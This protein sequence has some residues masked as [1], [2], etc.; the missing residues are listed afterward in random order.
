MG[1]EVHVCLEKVAAASQIRGPPQ[2]Q[3][4]KKNTC[5]LQSTSRNAA[6]QPNAHNSPRNPHTHGSDSGIKRTAKNQVWSC[7]K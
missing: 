4:N 3:E 2:A 5:I 6:V 1:G 7:D